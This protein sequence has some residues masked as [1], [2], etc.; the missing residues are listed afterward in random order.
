MHSVAVQTSFFMVAMCEY[1]LSSRGHLLSK[2]LQVKRNEVSPGGTEK[3]Q[4]LFNMFL[5]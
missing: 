4:A 3:I 2:V 1:F 5:P